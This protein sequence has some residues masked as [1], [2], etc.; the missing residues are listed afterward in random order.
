MG[1]AA[2]A[3]HLMKRSILAAPPTGSGRAPRRSTLFDPA[4]ETGDVK[5]RPYTTTIKGGWWRDDIK[6]RALDVEV[7]FHRAADELQ[8]AGHADPASRWSTLL[9]EAC[10]AHGPTTA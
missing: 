2:S 7:T 10:V 9:C 1:G 6:G 4:R 8:A 5:R 3:L